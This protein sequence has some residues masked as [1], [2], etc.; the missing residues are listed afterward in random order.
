MPNHK[1]KHTLIINKIILITAIIEPLFKI[2]QAYIIFQ[3]RNASDI[4]LT[5]WVD[6]NFLTFIWVWYA[7]ITKQ[8]LI[9]VYQGLFFIINT[10][11]IV[12]ALIYG[13]RWI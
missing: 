1:H 5:Y 6:T 8:K 13:G 7:V 10:L 9:L 12:G 11:I 4:S 3:N 2:P